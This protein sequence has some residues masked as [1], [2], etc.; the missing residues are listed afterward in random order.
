MFLR[1][2][3]LVDVAHVLDEV[4]L[5][6]EAAEGGAGAAGAAGVRAVEVG[7]AVDGALVALEVGVALEGRGGAVRV[8]ADEARGAGAEGDVSTWWDGEN[9]G[10]VGRRDTYSWDGEIGPQGVPGG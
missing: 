9:E 1:Q 4:V 3:D 8:H 5:A 6:G 10:W 2:H 7:F